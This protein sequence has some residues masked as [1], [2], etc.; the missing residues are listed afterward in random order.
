MDITIYEAARNGH[1]QSLKRLF[2]GDSAV[3]VNQRDSNGL[4]A[5]IHA[6]RNHRSEAT[7]FLLQQPGIDVDLADNKGQTPLWYAAFSAS[8]D[9]LWQLVRAGSSVTA[10]SIEG[11]T[12]LHAICRQRM[13]THATVRMIRSLVTHGADPYCVNH[14]DETPFSIAESTIEEARLDCSMLLELESFDHRRRIIICCDGTWNDRETEQPF[15]NVTK[16]LDCIDTAGF[17][18]HPK[19]R[20]Q[21]LVYYMDGIGTGT[22]W[23]GA[24]VDGVFGTSKKRLS[25]G[26]PYME[27]I[28]TMLDN[29]PLTRRLPRYCAEDMR[30]I[31]RPL[32]FVCHVSGPNHPDRVLSRCLY[33][34]MPRQLRQ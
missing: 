27:C 1:V 12:P 18:D 32:F 7:Q 31:S 25:S 9:G 19:Q 30:S 23:V 3:D 20:F 24:R 13:R 8:E 21:Q 16:I 17:G 26:F 14:H 15:T 6:V 28:E 4:S 29:L 34:A 11:D 10:A 5:L 2:T 22:T 33:R